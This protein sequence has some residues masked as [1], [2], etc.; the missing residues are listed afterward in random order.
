M[1]F[2][3]AQRAGFVALQR[4]LLTSLSLILASSIA[5]AQLPF[6]ESFESEPGGSYTL[7]GAFDDGGFDY[8]GRYALPD[9]DNGA[10]F[11]NGWDGSFGIHSQDNNGDSGPATV[12][13]DIPGIDISSSGLGS[14]LALFFALTSTDSFEPI[15]L[16]NVRVTSDGSGLTTTIALA[17]LSSETV[18]PPFDNYEAS[19][20]DGIVIFAAIDGG[21]QME[22]G[23]FSPPASGAVT[24]EAKGDLYMDM[25]GD[26]I[27]SG[28][29][30]T[31][32]LTDYSFS[33]VVPEPSGSL[34][35]VFALLGIAGIRRRR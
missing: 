30:L 14:T 11:A 5:Q 32:D 15:A 33:I 28:A 17:A 3:S 22:I 6:Q 35:A 29:I 26:G 16:D 9:V 19:E 24:M 27:G 8:F 12:T 23:R 18:N 21:T 2:S 34:L 31:A 20:G 13:V 10:R 25:D 4:I 7:S 1:T